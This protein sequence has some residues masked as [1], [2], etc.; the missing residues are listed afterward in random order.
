M[1]SGKKVCVKREL[2]KT[3]LCRHYVLREQ[4]PYKDKCKFAHGSEEIN[5]VIRHPKYKT[6][7]CKGYHST[8]FCPY[9]PRCHF[10]H[11]HPEDSSRSSLGN[12]P[13]GNAKKKWSASTKSGHG[14]EVWETANDWQNEDQEMPTDWMHKDQEL[15]DGWVTPV[16]KADPDFLEGQVQKLPVAWPNHF[17]ES[18]KD[19]PNTLKEQPTNWPNH[20][21]ESDNNWPNT[22]K[23]QQADWANHVLDASIDWPNQVRQLPADW[24]NWM[25]GQRKSYNST[26]CNENRI[27]QFGDIDHCHYLIMKQNLALQSNVFSSLSQSQ[28]NCN[29]TLPSQSFPVPAVSAD[30]EV[31]KPMRPSCFP[32]QISEP[33][34]VMRNKNWN[35]SYLLQNSIPNTTSDVD[36][37]D[38]HHQSSASPSVPR[39]L[40]PVLDMFQHKLTFSSQELISKVSS[41]L[42]IFSRNLAANSQSCISNKQTCPVFDIPNHKLILS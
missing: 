16:Q 28:E 23:K 4:C 27:N 26:P 8:G 6:E 37:F 17:Q 32:N 39:D 24:P 40:S 29:Y 22:L 36:S 38:W 7:L 1:A 30:L 31:S 42:E 10:I 25:Q 34:P 5:D 33:S 14:K 11:G 19:W 35:Q 12:K 18:D 13:M 3:E 2:Y 21:Q 15:P 41:V 20:I 9:G